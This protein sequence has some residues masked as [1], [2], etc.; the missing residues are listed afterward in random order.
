M[1]IYLRPILQF[2]MYELSSPY[3]TTLDVRITISTIILQM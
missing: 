3:I 2:Y 1:S